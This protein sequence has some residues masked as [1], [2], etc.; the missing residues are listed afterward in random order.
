M[1]M[2]RKSTAYAGLIL[3][4]FL[5]G[6]APQLTLY[7][8]D[9]FSPTIRVAIGSLTSGLAML[10]ISWHRLP[11]LSRRY[12]KLAVPTGVFLGAADILQKI[13]LQYTTPTNYA[14]LENLSV[15]VVPILLF[16]L[17]KKRPTLLTLLAVLLC[18]A[19]SLVLTGVLRAG[20]GFGAGDILCALSGMLYGVNI[21]VT[22][23]YAKDV[24]VSLYLSIQLLTVAVL[25][26]LS[27]VLLDAM[28]VEP[29]LLTTDI[30]QYLLLI[31]MVLTVSTLGWLIRTAAMKKVDPTVVA[32]MMPFSA[33]VTVFISV[34]AGTDT[35]SLS[36]FV[37][38]V[39]G[40]AAIL[41][42]GL[43]ERDVRKKKEDSK[44]NVT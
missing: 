39:L 32:V 36:L 28:G 14:F 8:Y 31:L 29:I 44:Q 42:S 2:N 40:L 10:L 37:G 7:F 33:V 38:A 21:A 13:G 22:G 3:V 30:R 4:I 16:F 35:L 34:L 20:G 43:G 24:C 26:F 18:L 19:S 41:L 12:F 17:V 5:W 25:G 27:A 6:A 11:L 9:Y 23:V 15:V 1:Q